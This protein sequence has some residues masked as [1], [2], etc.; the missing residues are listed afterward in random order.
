M[1]QQRESL[2]E[3]LSELDFFEQAE[4]LVLG[5]RLTAPRPLDAL[6]LEFENRVLR[7]FAGARARLFAPIY[8]A[9]R[10]SRSKRPSSS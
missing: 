8:R 3:N 7:Q 10:G 6:D 2:R 5:D 4:A 9:L 1:A